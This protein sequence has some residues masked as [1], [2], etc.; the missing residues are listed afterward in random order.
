VL[1][2]SVLLAL[3]VL[4]A[5]ILGAWYGLAE[6][7]LSGNWWLDTIIDFAGGIGT[8]VLAWFLF[9]AAVSIVAS[10][11]LDAVA[12]A[13]EETHYPRLPAPR[14][15]PLGEEIAVGVR[16]TALALAIN[17]ALLP[18]Y[19][20]L[21]FFPPFYGIVF[22]AIN[23][24]L[25]GREYFELA[26]LRRLPANEVRQVWR[27]NRARLVMGGIVVAVLLTVPVINFLAPIVAT[28]FMVHLFHGLRRDGPAGRF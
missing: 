14:R 18:V 6:I 10:F 22:Y 5:L 8:V 2:L 7:Q 4:A 11:F 9:P 28:A 16:F 26:A 24:Y 23:G 20:A 3:A 13:V 19:L 17:I 15:V 25:L 12:D 21:L 1:W 27:A